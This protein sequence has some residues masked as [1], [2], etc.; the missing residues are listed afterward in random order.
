[1]SALTRTMLYRVFD[2]IVHSNIPLPDYEQIPAG[3][4]TLW[5]T[6][7]SGALPVPPDLVWTDVWGDLWSDVGTTT[8]RQPVWRFAWH[9]PDLLLVIPK[10]WRVSFRE[11]VSIDHL[12]PV[13][14]H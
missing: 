7:R 12:P 2:L 13:F 1:M 14:E 6:R 5:V 3:A 8:P 4:P 9:G 11:R 10:V